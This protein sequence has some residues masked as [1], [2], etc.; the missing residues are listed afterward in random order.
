MALT[1][2]PLKPQHP[3]TREEEMTLEAAGATAQGAK[4][5]NTVHIA[6]GW[7]TTNRKNASS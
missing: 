6:S 7:R 4:E 1:K 2:P 5:R 3:Q